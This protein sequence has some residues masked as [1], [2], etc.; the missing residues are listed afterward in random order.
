MTTPDEVD[1]YIKPFAA[2]LAELDKGRVHT[3]LSE[4]LHDLVVA[5]QATG[6]AGTLTLTIDL[7]PI[8]RGQSDT[9][10][11]TAK[12]TLKAP[13]G[14][15]E[16]PTT[17]FFTDRAGNLTRED[18]NQMQLPLRLAGKANTA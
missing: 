1:E 5:V 13:A 15:D 7:R 3:R 12:T 14:D 18:P 16:T 17:V 11:L 2:T 8:K 4:Q 6:K 10:Q 9:L